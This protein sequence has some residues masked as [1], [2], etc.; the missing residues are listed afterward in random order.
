VKPRLIKGRGGVF[1]VMAGGQL[2]FSKRASGRFPEELE[3][4]EVLRGIRP[5]A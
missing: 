5:E 3:I 2:I 4:I 1:E